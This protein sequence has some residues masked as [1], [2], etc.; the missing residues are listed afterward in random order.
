MPRSPYGVLPMP[1]QLRLHEGLRNFSVRSRASD[2]F[3]SRT[4]AGRS[5]CSMGLKST[6]SAFLSTRKR[7]D[8]TCAAKESITCVAYDW[9]TDANANVRRSPATIKATR[10]GTVCVALVKHSR[11]RAFKVLWQRTFLYG[12]RHSCFAVEENALAGYSVVSANSS[13]SMQ[14]GP[15]RCVMRSGPAPAQYRP[16]TGTASGQTG[17]ACVKTIVYVSP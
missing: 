17:G 8:S 14:L 4:A 7:R 16:G 11:R 13:V 10:G 15:R 12:A 9:Y 5:A 6:R 1:T 3:S 2:A